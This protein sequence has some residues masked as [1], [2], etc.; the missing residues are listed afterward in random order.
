MRIIKAV[1]PVLA[2]WG[3]YFYKDLVCFRLYPVVMSAL[4]FSFFFVSLFRIP[5]CENI[6]RKTGAQLDSKGVAY[7]R[8]LTVAWTCLLGLNLCISLITV[9]LPIGI[10]AFYNGF[11]SYLIMGSFALGEFVYRKKI[12]NV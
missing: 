5:L 2:V 7:C 6:A 9:F 1:I 11:L 12:L 10:W 8:N 3:V 4:A